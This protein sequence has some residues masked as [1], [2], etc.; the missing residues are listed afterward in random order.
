M[1]VVMC[2]L[3]HRAYDRALIAFDTRFDLHISEV[4]LNELTLAGRDGGIAPFAA[5]LR[6]TLLLPVTPADRPDP[7]LIKRANDHR[8]FVF[9]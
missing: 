9:P 2:S 5:A 4:R 3:H 8:G 1:G 7:A 6:K